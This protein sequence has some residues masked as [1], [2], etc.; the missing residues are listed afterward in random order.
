MLIA[1]VSLR[2]ITSVFYRCGVTSKFTAT[3][4]N[5]GYFSPFKY[6]NRLTCALADGESNVFEEYLRLAAK[7]LECRR[8]GNPMA[9]GVPGALPGLEA[10]DPMRPESRR[11]PGA[12]STL[13]DKRLCPKA[14][15]TR[16]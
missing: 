13:S 1:I 8:M 12:V 4:C 3:T 7:A 9:I 6:L 10:E 5:L 11:C 15:D 14:A 16:K 2:K